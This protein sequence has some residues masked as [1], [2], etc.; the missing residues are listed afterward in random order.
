MFMI[1]LVSRMQDLVCFFVYIYLVLIILSP[2]NVRLP[3]G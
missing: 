2:L 1:P 3:A